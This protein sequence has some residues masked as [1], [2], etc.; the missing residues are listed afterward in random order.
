M[1]TATTALVASAIVSTAATGYSMYQ[2]KEAGDKAEASQRAANRVS[3]ASAQVQSARE[4]RR[5]IAQA[6]IAQAQNTANMGSQIQSSSAAAGVSSSLASQL[7]ANLGAQTQGINSQLNI[8]G[9]NQSAASAMQTGRERS[10]LAQG[11]GNIASTALQSYAMTRPQNSTL[12][13]SVD[14]SYVGSQQQG[15][16]G[17]NFQNWLNR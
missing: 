11:V 7:G 16:S 5:A 6:R 15:Y 3:Q 4:R 8:Q 13:N 17:A 2:Q 10:S 1:V 14:T 12:N 9:L